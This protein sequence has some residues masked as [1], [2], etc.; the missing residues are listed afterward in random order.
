MYVRIFLR[1]AVLCR[2][3]LCD[4]LIPVRGVSQV[5]SESEQ[6]RKPNI[7]ASLVCLVNLFLSDNWPQCI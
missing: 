6:A 5:N 3:R 4:G 7:A 2:N 1:C